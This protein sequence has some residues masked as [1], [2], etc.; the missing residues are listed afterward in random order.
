[1]VQA[2]MSFLKQISDPWTSEA[3]IILVIAIVNYRSYSFIGEL[4]WLSSGHMP[5]I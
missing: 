4:K 3:K 2:V 1:M 5:Q